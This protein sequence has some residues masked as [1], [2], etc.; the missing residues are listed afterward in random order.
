[1]YLVHT[2]RTT[3]T[4]YFPYTTLFRS[5]IEKARKLDIQE[6]VYFEIIRKKT[7]SLIAACCACGA[8]STQAPKETIDRLG[9]FGEKVGIAFQRSEEHTSE[10]Q[11][12][13][14]LVCRLLLE[15]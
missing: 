10:L 12:R 1:F 3:R 9:L 2:R 4:T 5:Q 6:E 8:S 15:K 7:A 11:S 14:N 13:E